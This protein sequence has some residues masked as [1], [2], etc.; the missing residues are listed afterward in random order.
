M[1]YGASRPHIQHTLFMLYGASRPH[2]QHTYTVHVVRCLE[3]PHIQHTLFM[4]YG[5]SRHHTYSTH[6]SCCTVPRDPTHTAHTVHVVRCLETPHIQHTLFMLY[7]ASRPHVCLETSHVP[8][9]PTHTAH[10]V[11][12]VFFKKPCCMTKVAVLY[13]SYTM[14]SSFDPPMQLEY[15]SCNLYSFILVMLQQ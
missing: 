15:M 3:T 10:T 5:A 13:G 4:L 14:T 9:E 7:G 12:V 6:C 2:I 11:H 8:R 1:L